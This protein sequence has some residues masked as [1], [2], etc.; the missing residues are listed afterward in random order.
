[1]VCIWDISVGGQLYSFSCH[2]ADVLALASNLDGSIIFSGG[3]DAIVRRFEFSLSETGDGISI[4]QFL[5][6][7]Y[8]LVCL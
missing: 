8:V 6:L 3:A 4:I 1:M 5:V 7:F 2:H